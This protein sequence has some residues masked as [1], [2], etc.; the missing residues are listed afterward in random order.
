MKERSEFSVLGNAFGLSQGGG[1]RKC[2]LWAKL[3]P[4]LLC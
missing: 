3:A 4:F 2:S 1:V